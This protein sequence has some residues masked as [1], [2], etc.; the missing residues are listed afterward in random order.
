MRNNS[1]V[2]FGLQK[3][4]VVFFWKKYKTSLSSHIQTAELMSRASG[5]ILGKMSFPPET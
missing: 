5:K 4:S 1:E 2:T 3:S